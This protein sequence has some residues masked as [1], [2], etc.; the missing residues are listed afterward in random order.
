MANTHPSYF[1]SDLARIL[2]EELE[3]STDNT[4]AIKELF[5]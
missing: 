4:D 3:Y 5:F 1:L 2:S